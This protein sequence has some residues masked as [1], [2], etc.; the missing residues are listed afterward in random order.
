MK[1]ED[2]HELFFW[3]SF[4]NL[5]NLY[6]SQRQT[7]QYW[8]AANPSSFQ[9]FDKKYNPTWHCIV[10]RNFGSYV[11]H[12]TKHFIYFYLGQVAILLFKSGW[13]LRD[14]LLRS[15][16]SL[17][18]PPE[19]ADQKRTGGWRV[20][21]TNNDIPYWCKTVRFCMDLTLFNMYVTVSLRFCFFGGFV[22]LGSCHLNATQLVCVD[23][24][25]L[26]VV[27]GFFSTL[28]LDCTIKGKLWNVVVHQL[29]FT[30][31]VARP[32]DDTPS[33]RF[34]SENQCRAQQHLSSLSIDCA[35]TETK[36]F[37]FKMI[38]VA[39]QN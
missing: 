26:S 5:S 10:G 39:N 37:G 34:D 36:Y 33:V 18:R 38:I 29:S 35:N 16:S 20:S 21:Y 12:E 1:W 2:D 22:F 17:P 8:P 6:L 4:R 13:E 9:E 25:R 32:S 11:T 31:G 24:L 14:G 3:N 7:P 23:A 30:S 28:A 19:T 27:K 15:L